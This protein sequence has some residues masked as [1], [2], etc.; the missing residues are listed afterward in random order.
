MLLE[1]DYKMF[2]LFKNKKDDIPTDDQRKL[3][4]LMDILYP[5]EDIKVDEN[6]TKYYIDYSLDSNL[7]TALS[8]LED[9]INDEATRTTVRHVVGALFKIRDLLEEMRD[10]PNDVNYYATNFKSDEDEFLAGLAD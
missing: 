3:K 5:P 7:Q 4:E 2:G 9:D 10:I 8:D 6:G 1:Q